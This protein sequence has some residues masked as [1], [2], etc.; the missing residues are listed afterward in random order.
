MNTQETKTIGRRIERALAHI[1]KA[2]MLPRS[3]LDATPF[4][5]DFSKENKEVAAI[6]TTKPGRLQKY[7]D[8][9]LRRGG[10][11]WGM[12]GYGEDRRWYQSPLFT[13][14]VEP[15]T[16]HLGIDIWLSAGT[17]IFLPIAGTIHSFQNNAAFL[18]YGPTI[19]LE[20]IISDVH[21]FTLYGHLSMDSLSGLSVGENKAAGAE[22][23]RIGTEEEN[24]N[25]AP[26]LHFQIIGDML[27]KRGDFPAVAKQSEKDL[28]LALCPNPELLFV[29]G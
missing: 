5:F 15:R 17:P 12:G 22:V 11:T 16:V 7:I 10:R 9:T 14:G 2:D 24:G 4:R 18:D 8:T 6:D 27:G 1:P 20:H 21:F 29:S 28:Y 26:H 3:F 13:N 23:G 25:W 19:I